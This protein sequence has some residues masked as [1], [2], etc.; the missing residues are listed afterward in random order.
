MS[1][2]ASPP[3]GGGDQRN[4][5]WNRAHDDGGVADARALDAGVLEQDH[6]AEAD[7][8]SE[9]N[10]HRNSRAQRPPGDNGEHG[11]AQREPHHGQPRRPEPTQRELRK[12][13]GEAPQHAR[14]GQRCDGCLV[15]ALHAHNDG[16]QQLH[17][18]PKI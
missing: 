9:H 7:R 5:Q 17:F 18:P 2:H 4:Q 13:H 3:K 16:G 14:R 1:T 10:P 6:A 12:R 8:P 15:L 11:R